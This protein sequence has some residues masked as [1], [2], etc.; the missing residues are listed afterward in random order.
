MY[1]KHVPFTFSVPSLIKLSIFLEQ[2]E[3]VLWPAWERSDIQTDENVAKVL[4]SQMSTKYRTD[5]NDG[6][7]LTANYAKGNTDSINSF[8]LSTLTG[9][10]H[11]KMNVIS[12]DYV[13]SSNLIDISLSVNHQKA[14]SKQNFIVIDL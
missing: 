9:P 7:I 1:T 4:S 6:W 3:T 8:M 12:L 10:W 13:F 14:L 11:S 5:N 2:N